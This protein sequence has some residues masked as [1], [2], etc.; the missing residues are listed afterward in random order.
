[1]N[2]GARRARTIFLIVNAVVAL[3]ASVCLLII[4]GGG[5]HGVPALGR[6]LVPDHRSHA[7]AAVGTRHHPRTQVS[8]DSVSVRRGAEL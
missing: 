5:L 6:K 4:L 2:A 8:T 7:Q 1:V 3:A